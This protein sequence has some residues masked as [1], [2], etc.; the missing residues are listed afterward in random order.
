MASVA[1]Q[2]VKNKKE[3][4]VYDNRGNKPLRLTPE[5]LA[6]SYV[7]V[8]HEVSGTLVFDA[9]VG[10]EIIVER[11]QSGANNEWNYGTF[12]EI[13]ADGT[14]KFFDEC[15]EQWLYFQF[16]APNAPHVVKRIKK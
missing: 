15:R 6:K 11:T 7:D 14:V 16:K 5:K 1:S 12:K 8:I 3:K 10:Q 4:K 2:I 13:E 9:E